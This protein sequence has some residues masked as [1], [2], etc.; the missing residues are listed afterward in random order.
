M[1][2]VCCDIDDVIFDFQGAFAARFGTNQQK[3]WTSSKLFIKRLISLKKDFW[4][5]LPVKNIPNFQPKAFVS[6]RSISKAWTKESLRINKIPGRS[7]V[8]QVPWNKS[9]VEVLKELGCEVF[10]DDK[11][12]TFKECNDNGIFCLLMSASHNLHYK[13]PLRIDNLDI[14]NILY[15]F[16]NYSYDKYLVAIHKKSINV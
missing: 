4:V 1:I 8:Y 6:A 7:K 13:T 2:N 10:I 15:L 3:R 5:S 12:A 11:F 9:K 16:K 14:N